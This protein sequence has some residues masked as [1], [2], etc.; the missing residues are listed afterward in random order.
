MGT[1]A[2]DTTVRTVADEVS[3][4]RLPGGIKCTRPTDPTQPAH[5]KSGL[6]ITE[7]EKEPRNVL[8]TPPGEGGFLS[9]KECFK[10][11]FLGIISFANSGIYKMVS[12]LRELALLLSSVPVF[13]TRGARVRAPQRYVDWL[14]L[15]KSDGG[16]KN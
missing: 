3:R 13:E 2:L 9:I 6:S 5:V 12:S 10:S 15:G 8:E 14:A 4:L 11:H 1:V 16:K 7:E